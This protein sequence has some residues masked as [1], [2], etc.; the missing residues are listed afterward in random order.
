MVGKSTKTAI[1]RFSEKYLPEPNTGCWL[2]ESATTRGY[3]VIHIAGGVQYAH[4][5]SYEHF[6]GPI[7]KGLSI[8][9][10]CRT[11]L[12]VNPAHLEPVTPRENTARGIGPSAKAARTGI[13]KSGHD[14]VGDNGYRRTN[15]MRGCHA[16]DRYKYRKFRLAHSRKH[17]AMEAE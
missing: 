3:G 2:W 7:P 12:C 10:L 6:V 5:F 14:L 17:K 13:C 4:R 11:P 8:D 9:H 15:G 1:E 16:C